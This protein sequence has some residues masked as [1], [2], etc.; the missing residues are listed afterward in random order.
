M[1]DAHWNTWDFYSRSLA[2]PQLNEYIIK[3]ADTS[4]FVDQGFMAKDKLANFLGA[5]QS[6]YND[7]PYHNWFHAVGQFRHARGVLS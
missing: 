6:K 3:M 4:G 7:V 5:L 1:S 2:K